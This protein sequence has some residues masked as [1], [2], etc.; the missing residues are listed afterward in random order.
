MTRLNLQCLIQIQKEHAAHCMGTKLLEIPE[1]QIL[2]VRTT[3]ASSLIG[4]PCLAH[5]RLNICLK[6]LA[7]LLEDPQSWD[8]SGHKPLCLSTVALKCQSQSQS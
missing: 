1:E 3:E 2:K 4:G 5:M 7:S 8:F 6:H